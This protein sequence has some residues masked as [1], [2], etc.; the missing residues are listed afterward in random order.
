MTK[1]W[2]FSW[3][4]FIPFTRNVFLIFVTKC[5]EYN[6]NMKKKYIFYLENSQLM[7]YNFYT[8]IGH[9]DLAGNT[10]FLSRTA[11]SSCSSIP[12]GV[13]TPPEVIFHTW[14]WFSHDFENEFILSILHEIK[15]TG[16]PIPRF[17]V[18]SCSVGRPLQNGQ[19]ISWSDR[20]CEK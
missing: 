9:L 2:R 14:A 8:A 12:Q 18:S 15:S 17:L 1:S 16:Q 13:H 5:K 3:K 20:N 11:I 10:F 7:E 19:R 4:E 6:R